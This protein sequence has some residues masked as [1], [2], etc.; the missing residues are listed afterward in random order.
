[1][2]MGKIEEFILCSQCEELF[3]DGF[4]DRLKSRQ[5]EKRR[6][7][8]FCKKRTSDY[9]FSLSTSGYEMSTMK[10][11]KKGNLKSIIEK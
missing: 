2:F 10:A 7:C 9:I 3:R 6:M 11:M 8:A 5:Q 1:M 4:K